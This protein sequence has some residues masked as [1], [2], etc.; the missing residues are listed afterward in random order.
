MSIGSLVSGRKAENKPWCAS[1]AQSG[2]SCRRVA[3]VAEGGFPE[4]G[5]TQRKPAGGRRSLGREKSCPA[6]P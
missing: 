1:R 4:E 6:N 3:R 5:S 2:M